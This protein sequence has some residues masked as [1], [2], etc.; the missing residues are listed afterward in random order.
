MRRSK[1][2]SRARRFERAGEMNK[3]GLTD[4]MRNIQF[5]LRIRVAPLATATLFAKERVESVDSGPSMR[6]ASTRHGYPDQIEC[7]AE[8][9]SQVAY[10]GNR[11]TLTNVRET[12]DGRVASETRRTF[13]SKSRKNYFTVADMVAIIVKFERVDRPKSSIVN[14][15][16][17]D[18]EHLFDRLKRVGSSA[19]VYTVRWY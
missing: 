4:A 17:I 7:T 5:R 14:E 18:R 15:G 16:C 2:S 11:I 13:A 1:K 10:I 3:P 12:A 8:E 19:N 6:L 9:C